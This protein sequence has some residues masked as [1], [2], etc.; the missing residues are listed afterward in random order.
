MPCCFVVSLLF[1]VAVEYTLLMVPSSSP[2]FELG[3][4]LTHW[5]NRVLSHSPLL[6]TL[7]AA[8]NTICWLWPT[9]DSGA[10]N[11]FQLFLDTSQV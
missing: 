4:I 6:N 7:F 11:G 10:V 3:F 2:P 9:I 1:F 5:L 8:L